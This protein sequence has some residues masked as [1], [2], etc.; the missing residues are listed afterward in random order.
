MQMTGQPKPTESDS[1]HTA[2]PPSRHLQAHKVKSSA[3]HQGLRISGVVGSFDR[4]EG[5]GKLPPTQA[6]LEGLQV[7]RLRMLWG[8]A[9][10]SFLIQRTIP[11]LM[12]RPV[13]SRGVTYYGGGEKE[14]VGSAPQSALLDVPETDRHKGLNRC[15]LPQKEKKK[16]LE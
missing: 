15:L 6:L 8:L 3:V 7:T 1:Q 2:T 12:G 13:N 10:H 4:K 14:E 5:S 16:K 11:H 9:Y